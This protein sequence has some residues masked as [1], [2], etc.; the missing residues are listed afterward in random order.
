MFYFISS[1]RA[2][3]MITQ[4]VDRPKTEKLEM[5]KDWH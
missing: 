3:C 5:M 1:T 4:V 2:L